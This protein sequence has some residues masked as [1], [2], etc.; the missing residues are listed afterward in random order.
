MFSL[1]PN[2]RGAALEK[3]WNR[4]DVYITKPFEGIELL[5]AVDSHL[6]KQDHIKKNFNSDQEN[7]KRFTD[8]LQ[9]NGYLTFTSEER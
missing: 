6:K 9:Q 5:K 2:Q 7:I 8:G 4:A 1:Q 3:G